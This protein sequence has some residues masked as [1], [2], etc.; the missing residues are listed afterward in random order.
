MIIYLS[1]QNIQKLNELKIAFNLLN[2]IEL[3]HE[4]NMGKRN[5]K[6]KTI[7]FKITF[8]RV[9]RYVFVILKII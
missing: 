5:V 4:N 8:I 9:L 2:I 6:N 7:V 1:Y 3:R